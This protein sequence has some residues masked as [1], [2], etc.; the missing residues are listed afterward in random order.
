MT[1]DGPSRDRER[2]REPF[3]S[4]PTSAGE[5]HPARE[6]RPAPTAFAFTTIATTDPDIAAMADDLAEWK[7]H[8]DVT[9]SVAT[10]QV[11]EPFL[12]DV[13]GLGAWF[14]V[15]SPHRD[16][17]RPKDEGPRGL[18]RSDAVAGNRIR[19]RAD[20][21]LDRGRPAGRLDPR[22]WKTLA[23]LAGAVLIGVLIGAEGHSYFSK[24]RSDKPFS[25]L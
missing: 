21:R 9:V 2:E 8:P 18:E 10:T 6:R 23:V 7:R 15:G 14:S 22:A 12:L 11:S 16:E 4:D 13:T 17:P 20:G 1:H 3:D 25:P 24:S 5:G 19:E